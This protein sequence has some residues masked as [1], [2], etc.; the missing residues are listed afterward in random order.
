MLAVGNSA[1][2]YAV[3]VVWNVFMAE[4]SPIEEREL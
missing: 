3:I 1:S 4:R 2:L